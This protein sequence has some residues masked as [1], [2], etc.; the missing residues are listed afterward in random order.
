MAAFIKATVGEQHDVVLADNSVVG[1]VILLTGRPEAFVDRVDEGDKHF[2]EVL[3]R[4][5]GTVRYILTTTGPGSGSSTINQ[6]FKDASRGTVAGLVPVFTSG[7]YVLL[8]V[9]ATDP[10]RAAA[11]QEAS[12]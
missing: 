1:A 3:D 8:S 5:W 2:L 7:R 11:Q 6:R 9:A 10:Q 12:P 4:P